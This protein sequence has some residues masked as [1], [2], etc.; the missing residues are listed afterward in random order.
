VGE[1]RGAGDALPLPWERAGERVGLK[2]GIS[3]SAVP[4]NA[5]PGF[6]AVPK[7]QPRSLMPS[8]VKVC[9]PPARIAGRS[10]KVVIAPSS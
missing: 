6:H 5:T 9:P 2:S 7:I 4:Q 3:S 1:G 10:F 8:G